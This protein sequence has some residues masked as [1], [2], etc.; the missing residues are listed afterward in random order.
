MTEVVH[1][2][3]RFC[4]V[5]NPTM[6]QELEIAPMQADLTMPMCIRGAMMGNQ[7]EFDY[8]GARWRIRGGECRAVTL[9]I[10]EIQKRLH[11][12]VP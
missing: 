1:L 4:L 5:L 7:S 11:A 6:C 9:P 8:Q 10:A 3:I 12:A 2:F